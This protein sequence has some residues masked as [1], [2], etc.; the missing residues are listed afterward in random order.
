VCTSAE[1]SRSPQNKK[2]PTEKIITR[3][4]RCAHTVPWRISI[5]VN[6]RP[7]GR[8]IW[9]NPTLAGKRKER[10]PYPVVLSVDPVTGVGSADV[11]SANGAQDAWVLSG[12][13]VIRSE[14]RIRRQLPASG[15][16]S[17]LGPASSYPGIQPPDSP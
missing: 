17:R 11:P 6:R 9:H 4:A 3:L 10:L 16:A 8:L 15:E 2:L 7:I 12:S 13:R 1:A 14:Q 5:L